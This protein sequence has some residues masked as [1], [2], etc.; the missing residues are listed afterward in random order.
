MIKTKAKKVRE[1]RAGQRYL[2][3]TP[4]GLVMRLA[5]L[6]LHMHHIW[7]ADFQ[8]SGMTYKMHSA[9]KALRT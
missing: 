9:F 2:T 8:T 1:K 5:A 6:G 3:R 7:R 4:P